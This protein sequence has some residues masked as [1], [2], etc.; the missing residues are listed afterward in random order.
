MTV[1]ENCEIA[2]NA[3]ARGA[4]AVVLRRNMHSLNLDFICGQ[5]LNDGDSKISSTKRICNHGEIWERYANVGLVFHFGVSSK[6]DSTQ[7]RNREPLLN[8]NKSRER[9]KERKGEREEESISRHSIDI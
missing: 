9:A 2:R 4:V 7:H 6:T 3:R 8:D 1:N 5:F